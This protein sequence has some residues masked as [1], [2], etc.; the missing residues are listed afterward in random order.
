[1]LASKDAIERQAACAQEEG[2]PQEEKSSEEELQTTLAAFN[3]R[4][5]GE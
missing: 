3:R 4:A 5:R 2:R 1:M